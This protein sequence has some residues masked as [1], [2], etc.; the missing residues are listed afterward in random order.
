MH[1]YQREAIVADLH[2]KMVLLTGPRQAGKTTLTFDV[3]KDFESYQYLNYDSLEDRRIIEQT[4]WFQATELITFYEIHKMPNWKNYLKG[5]YDTKGSEQKILVTG[6]A[7]L[8]IFNQVGDSLAGR[9]FLHRL[10][11]LS[12]AELKKTNQKLD[13][14]KLLERGCFPEPFL[15]IDPI[16]AKR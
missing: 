6:R 4:S 16:D 2:K 11:P 13:L 5:I 1:R 10:L 12:I 7:R 15:A 14:D 8:D 9:Y 3:A